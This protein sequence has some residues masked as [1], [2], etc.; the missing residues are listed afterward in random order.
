MGGGVKVLCRVGDEYQSKKWPC[1]GK[2]E[3]ISLE[4]S[5]VFDWFIYEKPGSGVGNLQLEGLKVL[6]RR[7]MS[8]SRKNPL[9]MKVLQWILLKNSSVFDWFIYEKPRSGV[10]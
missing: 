4:N 2:A 6:C 7:V 10:W 9:A 5:S 3:A 1:N 8:N